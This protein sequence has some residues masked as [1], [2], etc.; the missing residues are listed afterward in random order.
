MVERSRGRPGFLRV[1]TGGGVRVG[2]A[3]ADDLVEDVGRVRLTRLVKEAG[4]VVR[5]DGV[6][7]FFARDLLCPL[8]ILSCP[9][10]CG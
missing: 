7:K 8:W 1:D 5:E 4:D 9:E 6:D 3:V 10:L 2:V